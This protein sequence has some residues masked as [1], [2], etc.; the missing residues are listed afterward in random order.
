MTIE[1]GC[2]LSWSTPDPCISEMSEHGSGLQCPFADQLF[3]WRDNSK[4]RQVER[5]GERRWETL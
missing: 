1:D 5:K 3:V 2:D 4:S